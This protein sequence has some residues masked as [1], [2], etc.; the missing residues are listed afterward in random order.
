MNQ[1]VEWDK[2][3][4]YRIVGESDL[5]R[6][7]V[8]E[9]GKVARSDFN[10]LITGEP[11]VGKELAA[12]SIHS[13]SQRS[14]GNFVAVNCGGI[15]EGILQAELFGYVGGSFTDAHKTGRKG[16]VEGA[17][18][19]TLFLDE[20]GTI[21]SQAQQA[22]LRTLETKRVVRVGSYDEI[23][24]DF[25]LVAATNADLEVEVREGRM[26]QDFYDRVNVVSFHLP[27]LRE[28]REDIPL[29]VHYFVS[30]YCAELG[31]ERKA[32]TTDA[33]KRLQGYE[34]PGNIR[35]LENLV[36]R[37]T[38]LSEAREVTS[39]TIDDYL[40]KSTGPSPVSSKLA[41]VQRIF[42]YGMK[43]EEV[44]ELLV[45]EAITRTGGNQSQ[46]AQLLGVSRDQ[47]R[48]RMEHYGLLTPPPKRRA[49]Q[50]GDYVSGNGNGNGTSGTSNP[51]KVVEII[52]PP[53][54]TSS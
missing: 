31:I 50:Q 3:N 24:V 4:P 36:K 22:L 19:G 8:K 30:R 15:S 40:K 13:R 10:V 41:L 34:W 2:S 35:E 6:L 54:S 12:R 38:V 21:S 17:A 37:C 1:L 49:Q 53:S 7:V 11:G 32:F 45:K 20:I 16:K 18:H 43:L 26:R 42:E 27:P 39:V 44:E 51:E 33:I 52:P 28:R 14:K 29:L 9:L 47:F 23:P 5:L 46:A 48:Y 25:R